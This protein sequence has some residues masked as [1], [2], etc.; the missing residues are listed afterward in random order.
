MRFAGKTA[1]VTGGAS[2]IGRATVDLFAA[3]GATVILGDIDADAGS[4]IETYRKA[5]CCSAA[6]TSARKPISRG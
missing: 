4:S 3:E 2:G 6:A 5:A 1:V